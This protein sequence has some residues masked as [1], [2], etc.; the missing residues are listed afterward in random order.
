[1][2]YDPDYG[3]VFTQARCIASSQGWALILHGSATRDLDLLACPWEDRAC[4]P[5]H[6]LNRIADVCELNI[7]GG[8]TKKPHGRV[9]H[10]LMFKTFNDPRFIDLS[11]MPRIMNKDQVID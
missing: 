4:K 1:V 6:L 10:T 11:I 5:E 8:P 2:I 3:R 9:A 7:I